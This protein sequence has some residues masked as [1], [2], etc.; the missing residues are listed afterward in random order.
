[1]ISAE[2][3]RRFAEAHFPEAPEKLAVPTA[4]DRNSPAVWMLFGNLMVPV[5]LIIRQSAGI[6]TVVS[7]PRFHLL[8]RAW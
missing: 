3:A 4:L 5:L 8:P 6:V 2:E 1:M 7:R